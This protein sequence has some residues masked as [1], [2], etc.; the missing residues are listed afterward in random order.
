MRPNNNKVWSRERFIAGPFQEMG[1][2]CLKN[3]ELPKS[4]Q[5]KPFYWKGEG[6]AW[7]VV[8]HFLVL[9]PLFL[10]SGHGQVMMFLSTST[11]TDVILCS[12]KKGQGPKAQF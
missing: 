2:S 11:K 6:G 5:A 3:P 4:F 7:L 10:R 9:D 1:G 8:A 12:D